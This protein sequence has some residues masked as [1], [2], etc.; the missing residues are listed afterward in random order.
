MEENIDT[1]KK[2]YHRIFRPMFERDNS[3]WNGH[4]FLNDHSYALNPQ[5]YMRAFNYL[6]DD[7]KNLFEYIEPSDKNLS[8]YSHYIQQLLMR[9][10]VEVEANFKA[11]FK[12]NK[13]ISRDERNWTMN[14]YR[15]I[16]KS[17]HLDRYIVA[18]P[19]W[20]GI[21]N[22]FQPFSEWTISGKSLH[23]YDA[24]N[25]SKHDRQKNMQLANFSN[26]LYAFSALF[27]VLTAQF[28]T[29]TYE[30]GCTFLACGGDDSDY[31]NDMN[32]GIGNYLGFLSPDNW[33]E[34]EKYDFDWNKLKNESE[35]F[36]KY[37]YDSLISNK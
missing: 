25:K 30:P 3:G 27:V 21:H 6:Q 2:P 24:Y 4:V 31:Y 5:A 8:T 22:K 14:D 36:R 15:L 34:E 32:F 19:I 1:Y 17:H 35:R 12:E 37:D 18:F 20:S 33:T 26:L 13:Y 29:E 10:C 11:I 23:W 16:N 28:G 9:C 7:I